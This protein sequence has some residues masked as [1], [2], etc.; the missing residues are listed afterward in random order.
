MALSKVEPGT[1]LYILGDMN[2]NYLDNDSVLSAKYKELL[3]SFGFEQLIDEPTR[4][5]PTSASL[6]DHILTKITQRWLLIWNC[7]K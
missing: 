4:I 7:Q 3:D 1:E 2:I 6:I 5:T